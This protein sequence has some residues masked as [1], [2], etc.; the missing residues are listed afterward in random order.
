[1]QHFLLILHSFSLQ[2]KLFPKI[3]G[4]YEWSA[5][6][7]RWVH[8]RKFKIFDYPNKKVLFH[9]FNFVFTF[10]QVYLLMGLVMPMWFIQTNVTNKFYK[11]Q[12]P[13]NYLD[14]TLVV[15]FFI[16]FAIESIADQQQWLFQTNKYKW[17]DS[18]KRKEK[19]NFSSE[20]IEEFKRGFLTKGLFR[21]TRHPNFFAEISLWWIIYGFSISS[22]YSKLQNNFECSILIN[23]SILAPFFLNLLFHGSTDLTE[24]I[25]L[26]KYPKYVEYQSRV[27]RLFPFLIIPRKSIK[28]D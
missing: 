23:Y 24:K 8:V 5:E 9:I 17:I 14:G 25:T 15:S 28:S 2:F 18:Q 1:M 19:T 16:F 12:E 21:F 4:G 20:E 27:S 26:S 13:F 10:F 11:H 7:Y 22:Q 3:K 6:D